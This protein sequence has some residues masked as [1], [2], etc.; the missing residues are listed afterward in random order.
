MRSFLFE[1]LFLVSFGSIVGLY[2]TRGVQLAALMPTP[3]P[4]SPNLQNQLLARG[5]SS[6][7]RILNILSKYSLH[8]Q[9]I[10]TVQASW[11]PYTSARMDWQL[12]IIYNIGD[13][14]QIGRFS[15]SGDN[16]VSDS[17]DCLFIG[18][19]DFHPKKTKR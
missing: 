9:I 15:S 6:I 13:I 17:G 12:G 2:N 19:T 4:H 7:N 11:V 10:V 1:C 14:L 5:S 8:H 18:R 16:F 3:S